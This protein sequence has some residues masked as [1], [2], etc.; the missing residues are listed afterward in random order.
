M[1][2][3]FKKA[4]FLTACG[5]AG[6]KYSFQ[7]V[8]KET[9][10]Y[11]GYI[12][13]LAVGGDPDARHGIILTANYPAK[14]AG[15]KAGM[16]L[17]QARQACPDIVFVTPRMDL[18]LRFSNMVREIY[19]D[20][21]NLLEPFGIDENWL[22]VTGSGT[23][24]GDG[25]LIAKEINSRVKKELGITVSIGISFNKIFA[26]LGSDFKKPDGITTIF[27]NEYR[28]KVW[29]LPVGDLL[30][31][32]P[33]T[34]R[35]L[36]NYGIHTIGQLAC[37]DE[38]I[39]K[40]ILGKAGTILWSFANGYD[41][42]PVVADTTAAPIKS[43]GNSTTSPRDLMNNEDVHLVFYMLAESVASRLKK[44]GFRCRT[45]EI[46]V[47]DCDL[48]TFTRQMKLDMVT[49]I[50]GE[51]AEAADRLFVCN[52]SWE[53]PVRSI[54]LRAADLV[55]VNYCEQMD[56]FTDYRFRDKR[57]KADI[58]MD[59]LRRRFGKEILQRGTVYTDLP[60]ANLGS[61]KDHFP[62]PNR[63]LNI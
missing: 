26:K 57:E 11:I 41:S 37:M 10:E 63:Y 30:Y 34:Q 19:Y 60:L 23:V 1:A 36:N 40:G 6:F 38:S 21:T 62:Y 46:S 49:D 55:T 15:V 47:R 42:S 24:R 27:R 8:V 43:I 58:M 56:M 2:S 29:R 45:V 33:N 17:W 16:A 54:G 14:R 52:Y 3:G 25:L 51:L 12:S 28:E 53:K 59:D 22:D 32:G 35:K 20:Y 7:I 4:E 13:C 48:E 61:I 5:R 50:S 39:I 18:Y 31:V 9:S 44:H